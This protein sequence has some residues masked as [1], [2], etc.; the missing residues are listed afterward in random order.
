MSVELKKIFVV[1]TLVF[2]LLGGVILMAPL[3]TF[4]VAIFLRYYKDGY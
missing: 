4:L 2:A 3:L 1:H